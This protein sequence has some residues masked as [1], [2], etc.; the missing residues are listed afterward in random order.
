MRR[1]LNAEVSTE[2]KALAFSDLQPLDESS[3]GLLASSGGWAFRSRFSV[4][5]SFSFDDLAFPTQG[6]V[7]LHGGFYESSYRVH[8]LRSIQRSFNS[9]GLQIG[10]RLVE[11]CLQDLRLVSRGTIAALYSAQGIV[12]RIFRWQRCP[13][14]AG[15]L[16]PE[17]AHGDLR[18]RFVIPHSSLILILL[19]SLKMPF[20]AL[21]ALALRAFFVC[22]TFSPEFRGQKWAV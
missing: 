17:N 6:S 11:P 5:T 8:F 16:V 21:L 18:V 19:F 4:D 12:M 20:K 9:A 1:K 14:C 3:V 15:P 7:C 10:K 13:A 22:R 2:K